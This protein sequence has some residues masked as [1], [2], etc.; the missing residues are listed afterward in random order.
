MNMISPINEASLLSLAPS[1]F[2]AAP[3]ESRS[4]RYGYVSSIDLIRALVEKGFDITAAS[5]SKPKDSGKHNFAKHMV[6]MRHTESYARVQ[7]AIIEGRAAGDT[8]T[9][10]ARTAA[11][12]LKNTFAE[13][14][15]TNSHDGTSAVILHAGLFRLDCFNGLILA[16]STVASIHVTHSKRLVANVIDGA[17]QL[18]EQTPVMLDAVRNWSQLQLERPERVALADAARVLRFGDN[19]GNVASTVTADQILDARRDADT[20]NDLWTTFNRVQENLMRGG[21]ADTR[22]GYRDAETNKWKPT[23]RLR[24]RAIKSIDGDV[25]LNKGLWT[26]AEGLAKAKLA[27]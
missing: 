6:R 7:Q 4:Q 25:R 10:E 20:G 21:L 13:I 2:A 3:H 9:L 14:V 11:R 17:F 8:H 15:L 22:P 24:T 18:A 26:L 16:D 27:A 1:I 23:R 19:E 12:S 5:Q